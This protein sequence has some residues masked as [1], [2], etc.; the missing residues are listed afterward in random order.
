MPAAL[1][2]TESALLAGSTAIGNIGQYFAFRMPHWDDDVDIT[3]K[4]V[5][6]L[7]LC[8]AQPVP[9]LIHSN[10]DDGFAALFTDLS[11][12]LGA[13]FLERY[14]VEDLLG[15]HLGHCYGHTF[16]DPVS[17]WAFQRALTRMDATKNRKVPG[18]MVYGNTTAYGPVDAQNYAAMAGYLGVDIAAQHLLAS[19]HAVTPIPVSEARRIPDIDETVDA[20]LFAA[21]LMEHE[22]SMSGNYTMGQIDIVT[23]S[24][25][26]GAHTFF[27]RTMA[28][29]IDH[30][31]DTSDAVEMLLTLKRLGAR[32][33]E[34]LYGP[35]AE[36]VNAVSGRVP[37][38]ETPVIG[39][40]NS[41]ADRILENVVE[42]IEAIRTANITIC[43]ATTDVHEYGKV[44][45]K[46]YFATSM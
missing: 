35:G 33:L 27:A 19:G 32:R 21:R 5:T 39:E 29:L 12:A 41:M 34:K 46:R 24:L 15:C 45:L 25:V 36:D 8:A 14:I 40:L 38:V 20:C 7:A 4:T 18:T 2:N 17:R 22:Q 16:S 1:E 26:E 31:I 43:I 6:A 3:E 23:N 30:G 13:V 37:L 9:V 10:V 28:G 11:C 42:H 44:C